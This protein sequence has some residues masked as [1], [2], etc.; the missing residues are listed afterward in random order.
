[1]LLFLASMS[2]MSATKRHL[3]CFDGLK[4][5]WKGIRYDLDKNNGGPDTEATLGE[6]TS[7]LL[8]F[9]PLIVFLEEKQGDLLGVAVLCAPGQVQTVE[10]ASMSPP[11]AEAAPSHPTYLAAGQQQR[12]EAL[13]RHRGLGE[14]QRDEQQRHK[15]GWKT[16]MR[17]NRGRKLGSGQIG[18]APAGV[19]GEDCI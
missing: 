15:Q 4:G 14:R 1:M 13:S 12:T 2:G 3:V 11:H 9:K 6:C 18:K 19:E 16:G 17:Q 8:S 10:P 5:F 7:C